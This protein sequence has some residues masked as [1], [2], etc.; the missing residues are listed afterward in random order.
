MILSRLALSDNNFLKEALN[1]IIQNK[2]QFFG[3]TLKSPP[4]DVL[5]AMERVGWKTMAETPASIHVTRRL[6]GGDK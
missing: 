4:N 3:T 2:N 1:G 5:T 6:G